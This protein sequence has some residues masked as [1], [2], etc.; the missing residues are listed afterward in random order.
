MSDE[1][2]DVVIAG[3]GMAGATLALA[4]AK[5]GLKAAV[6]DAQALETQLA[7]T[8]DGRASAIAY[9]NFRQFRALGLGP[10]LEPV[11]QPIRAIQVTDAAAPGAARRPSL[12]AFVAFDSADIADRSEG[13]PLGWMIENRQIRAALNSALAEAGVVPVAPVQVTGVD[14]EPGRAVMRLADGRSLTAPLVV[15]AEGRASAV[16]EAAGIR[17]FGWRYPQHGVVATVQL[18]RPHDGVA[19][20]LFMGGSGLAILPLTD[21][22]ASLVWAEP[23]AAAAAL[24]KGSTEAFEAHLAR[25]FGSFLGTPR[26][27]GPRFVYPLSFMLAETLV[28]PRVALVGDA[29]HGIHPVAGQGLNLGLKDV[30]ALVDVLVDAHSLGEDIGSAVVLERYAR[31]RRFDIAAVAAASDAFTRFF[32]MSGPATRAVRAAGFALMNRAPP[33]RRI[34]MLAA[35]ADLGELPRLLKGEVPA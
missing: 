34:A 11:A 30:A 24:V 16:R 12:P 3:A 14:T 19:H 20:Q 17:T 22:R 8:F 27:V 10:A 25:R 28:A 4:L 13:E 18:E 21:D 35:G 6:A 33:L 7:P 1:A 23:P 9:A 31:W 32:A 26:L 29:G 5:A 2:F 15:G